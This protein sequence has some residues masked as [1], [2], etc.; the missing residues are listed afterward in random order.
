MGR[1]QR[2]VAGGTGCGHAHFDECMGSQHSGE[3][4]LLRREEA[5]LLADGGSRT[6]RS[7]C[8]RGLQELETGGLVDVCRNDSLIGGLLC[9]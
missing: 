6:L 2:T 8:L 5:A 3:R 4:R 7:I 1:R 9:P